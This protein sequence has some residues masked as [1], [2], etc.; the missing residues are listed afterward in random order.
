MGRG[1]GRALSGGLPAPPPSCVSGS[2][3]PPQVWPRC[4]PGVGRT[5]GC[6]VPAGSGAQLRVGHIPLRTHHQGLPPAPAACPHLG[7]TKTVLQ[8]RPLPWGGLAIR[9]P[10]CSFGQNPELSCE[11]AGILTFRTRWEELS[12]RGT[13]V[14]QGPCDWETQGGGAGFSSSATCLGQQSAPSL[15]QER[16]SWAPQPGAW[17]RGRV[18][19]GRGC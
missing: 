17:G 3:L 11:E 6:S 1:S 18:T 8:A 14:S 7:A 2:H 15:T 13:S 5:W 19:W 10:A 9:T 4:L 12:Q 16:A